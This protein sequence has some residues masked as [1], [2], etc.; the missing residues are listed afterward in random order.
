M[1]VSDDLTR[2]TKVADFKKGLGIPGRD[3]HVVR[4]EANGRWLLYSTGKGLDAYVSSSTD[5]LHWH[6]RHISGNA[7]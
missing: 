7:G 1:A 3:S 6:L 2:W 5:L 4:D